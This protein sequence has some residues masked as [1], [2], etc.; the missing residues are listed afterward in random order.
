MLATTNIACHRNG[1]DI[2][3][4]YDERTMLTRGEVHIWTA[5]VFSSTCPAAKLEKTLSPGEREAAQRFHY[6]CHRSAYIFAHGVLRDILSR[7]VARPPEEI[8]FHRDSFGKPF[9][10]E[11]GARRAPVFNMSHSGS[12]VLIAL[13]CDGH[14]GVDVEAIRPMEHLASIAKS[15]FTPQECAFIMRHRPKN[16]AHAFFRCWTRKEAY[17]KALGKGLSIPLNAFDTLIAAGQSGRRLPYNADGPEV[18]NWWLADLDVPVGYLGAV[19]V[20]KGF[21]RLIYS[22]WNPPETA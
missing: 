11:S 19:A 8:G 13:A 20:E 6:A 16:Q 12:V 14:I 15:N 9:L 18:E 1:L 7:Y 21:D 10:V 2:R 5:R 22:E 3:L 4:S 17:I